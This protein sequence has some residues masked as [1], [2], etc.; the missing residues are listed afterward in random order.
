MSE[1]EYTYYEFLITLSRLFEKEDVAYTWYD[2]PHLTRHSMFV[3]LYEKY[4]MN[5]GKPFYGN[6]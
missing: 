2:G 1:R 4:L 3:H 5:V 6:G